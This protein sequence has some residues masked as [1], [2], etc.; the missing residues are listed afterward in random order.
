MSCSECLLHRGGFSSE[1]DYLNFR[2][3]LSK[4]VDA[5]HLTKSQHDSLEG[6]FLKLRYVCGH[7]GSC[8]VLSV[9]DQ[10]Y[11]GGW[12]EAACN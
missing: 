1:G 6:P 4:A 12:E 5:G 2:K 11:R 9:P 7:C 3:A 10:A 8:W